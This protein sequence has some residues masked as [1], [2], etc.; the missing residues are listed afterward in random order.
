M[1]TNFLILPDYVTKFTH[2][3]K[4]IRSKFLPPLTFT[5]WKG[6]KLF[7]VRQF[8]DGP[9][10]FPPA[11]ITTA[12][13]IDRS[14]SIISAGQWQWDDV[15]H[16]GSR[17][18]LPSSFILVFFPSLMNTAPP[19]EHW[20]FILSLFHFNIHPFLFLFCVWLKKNTC[21]KILLLSLISSTMREVLCRSSGCAFQL[22]DEIPLWV[23]QVLRINIDS[24]GPN[25]RLVKKNTLLFYSSFFQP[26]PWLWTLK[27]KFGWDV[28]IHLK[29]VVFLHINP[30]PSECA[31]YIT[32]TVSL[33]IQWILSRN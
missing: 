13:G 20:I 5:F 32:F 19:H 29:Y 6:S 31:G 1:K 28:H 23:L 11:A 4:T 24:D 3:T 10:S 26:A 25:L 14:Y 27:W 21:C 33:I 8:E 22:F 2:M 18:L 7:F 17:T 30:C 12:R 15:S 16:S 9:C